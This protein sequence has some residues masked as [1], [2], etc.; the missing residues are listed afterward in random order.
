MMGSQLN[1]L[2]AV[3][4]ENDKKNGK[5]K[6]LSI[7][8]PVYVIIREGS[9]EGKSQSKDLRILHSCRSKC[10]TLTL[11][12]TLLTCRYFHGAAPAN[13]VVVAAVDWSPT[14]SR[15]GHAVSN[16]NELP[17]ITAAVVVVAVVVVV[18]GCE[19]SDNDDKAA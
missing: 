6:P 7:Q 13:V 14:E 4:T 10:P 15:D 17:W 19:L 8:Y 3:I 18:A 5:P 2:L 16:D 11:R 9:P 12:G 1:L